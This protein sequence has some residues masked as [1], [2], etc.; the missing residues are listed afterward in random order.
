[1]AGN[2]V[3]LNFISLFLK[4]PLLQGI[5]IGSQII[6]VGVTIE[7]IQKIRALM[8]SEIYQ[9]YF[10]VIHGGPQFSFLI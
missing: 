5:G 2:V 8:I 6:I 1:M 3:F 9:K 10:T 7:V 4:L